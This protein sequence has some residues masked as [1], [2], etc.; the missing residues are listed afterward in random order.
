MNET[1]I[2][3]RVYASIGCIIVSEW[4]DAKTL[5]VLDV[6]YCSRVDRPLYLDLLNHAV[7]E[8]V[9][10][11]TSGNYVE[12]RMKWMCSRNMKCLQ[13]NYFSAGLTNLS[14]VR[15]FIKCTGSRLQYVSLESDPTCVVALM[16]LLVTSKCSLYSLQIEYVGTEETETALLQAAL[17][18]LAS[19]SCAMIEELAVG[20]VLDWPRIVGSVVDLPTLCMVEL[21]AARDEEVIC[22]CRAAPGRHHLEQ[23]LLFTSGLVCHRTILSRTTGLANVGSQCCERFGRG[24]ACNRKIVPKTDAFAPVE[25]PKSDEYRPDCNHYA[26]YSIAGVRY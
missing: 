7:F 4:L 20:V 6:A 23:L 17:I 3:L 24:A 21:R 11:D 9:V 14:V 12:K 25:L 16:N 10:T 26:V 1:G 19:N 15:D 2:L 8:D 13:F 22:F 5:T 18:S